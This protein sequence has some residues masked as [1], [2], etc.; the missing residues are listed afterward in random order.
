MREGRGLFEVTQEKLRTRHLALRTERVYLQW[1]RRYVA[2]H[3]RRHPREMGAPEVEAFLSHLATNGRVSA[4]TQNQALQAI[5]FLYKHVLDIELPW[6]DGVTRANRPKRLPVV[7]T[8][9]QVHAVLAELD[10]VPLLVASLLY[11]GGLRL[12][13][14]MQLRVKDI[15]MERG[16]IIVRGGKGAK[17][18]VTVLPTIVMEPLRRHLGR[19]R[20][21]FLRQRR[22]G[23]PGVTLPAALLRKYPDAAAKWGWQYVFPA[24][25]SCIDV[26]SGLP[27]QHHLHERTIQRAVK[28]A[29][30]KAGILQPASCHTFR[31]CFATHL[32]ESGCDIRTVQEL[33]GHA[34]VRT[35]MIYTHVLGRGAMGVK[36]PLD[37][38]GS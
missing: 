1:I 9:S 10:G 16:E 14:A 29:I 13:E 4:S 24:S 36:S 19:L 37:R 32:L 6:L 26:Y 25:E 22:S 21:Q 33:L 18:R 2:F 3:H 12:M 20:L 30:K 38:Q 11:G 7:L 31:H 17:D 5:L 35:T 28:A 34:D 15:V 23:A 27:A 8:V